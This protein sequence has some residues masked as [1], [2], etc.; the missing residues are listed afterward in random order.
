MAKRLGAEEVTIHIRTTEEYIP[1]TKDEIHE[2]KREGV[3]IHGLRT[4][5]ELLLDEAGGFR[6]EVP[7]KPPGRLAQ[8]RTA[9]GHSDRRVRV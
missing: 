1:V 5:V 3:S 9:P 7:A 8:R 4:P 6:G 2:A